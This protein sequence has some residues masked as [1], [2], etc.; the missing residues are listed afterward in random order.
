L[1]EAGVVARGFERVAGEGGEDGPIL[2]ALLQFGRPNRGFLMKGP[3][4]GGISVAGGLF[5]GAGKG[6][7]G[8]SLFTARAKASGD[9]G[10]EDDLWLS[11]RIFCASQGE[12]SQEQVTRPVKERSAAKSNLWRHW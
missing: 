5:E 8:G 6:G 7:E 2:E 3:E 4:E 10:R 1:S 9:G 12:L 11:D